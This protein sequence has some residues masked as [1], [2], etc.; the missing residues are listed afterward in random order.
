MRPYHGSIMATT[1]WAC[2]SGGHPPSPSAPPI[3][4]RAQE[5][6]PEV[7][8][9]VAGADTGDTPRTRVRFVRTTPHG[10]DVTGTVSVPGNIRALA[11][12]GPGPVVMLDD[13]QMGHVSTEGYERFPEVP[14]A[15]WS[16]PQPS[17][18][19]PSMPDEQLDPPLWRM[20]VDSAGG[21][22]QA[23]CDWGSAQHG[24]ARHCLPEGDRCDAWV[25]A[26]VWPGV[27]TIS[28]AEPKASFDSND[29]SSHIPIP[30]VLPSD[31][32]KT[33]IVGET[34]GWSVL[35][36]TEGGTT[37]QY[38][39]DEEHD[40]RSNDGVN[41]LTWLSTTPPMFLTTRLMGCRGDPF[42]V[43]FEGCKQSD[44]YA[45]VAGGPKELIV[46]RG[47]DTLWLRWHDHDLG[48]L[49]DVSMLAF[50]PGKL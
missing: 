1:M 32:I 38:P 50:A 45:E 36:C 6:P 39:A 34:A 19:D 12:V 9:V 15:M 44:R 35:R 27:L 30:S 17:S 3:A 46:L 21:L 37:T 31:A 48:S 14:P 49:D 4:A 23:R 24:I 2:G 42:S 33:E 40:P 7:E 11:W 16:V 20:I 5:T 43:V 22:W 26:R 8:L 28:R 29:P 18:D 13:G 47:S 25:Y 41:E 10:L